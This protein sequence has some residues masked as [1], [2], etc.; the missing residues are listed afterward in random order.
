VARHWHILVADD[1]EDLRWSLSKSLQR[2]G[3]PYHVTCVGDG[4]SAL[5]ELQERNYD[6]V[7]SDLRMPGVS[8]VEL[9][10]EI[11]SRKP[12]VP[13]IVMTAYGSEEVQREA[14]RHNA[15]YIEKP[16]D[17][18]RLRELIRLTLQAP[19][20]VSTTRQH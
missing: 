4:D 7:V 3:S 19:A 11:R 2:K 1:E 18:A 12:Q 9:I 15:L 14:Q 16:F 20:Q 8:G 13:I 10:R 17:I 6:L 5:A